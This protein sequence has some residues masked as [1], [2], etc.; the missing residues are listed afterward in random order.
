MTHRKFLPTIFRNIGIAYDWH[1]LTDALG[2]ALIANW[3]DASRAAGL[4]GG[5]TAFRGGI[6]NA[7]RSGAIGTVQG[8]VRGRLPAFPG[9]RE[10]AGLDRPALARLSQLED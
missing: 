2:R 10:A 6:E 8:E 1:T 4:P 5:G 9:E 3:R 7:G